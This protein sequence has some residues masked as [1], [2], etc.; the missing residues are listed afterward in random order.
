M[1]YSSFVV[2]SI[3]TRAKSTKNWLVYILHRLLLEIKFRL[4]AAKLDKNAASSQISAVILTVEPSHLFNLCLNSVQLQTLQ[5]KIIEIVRNISPVSHAAQEGLD[6]VQT[7]YYVHVDDDMVLAPSCFQRLYQTIST[8][9]NCAQVVMM[10]NDPIRGKINGIRMYR[11]AAVQSLGFHPLEE[12]GWDR[13]MRDKLVQVGWETVTLPIIV[14]HHHPVYLPNETFWKFRFFGEK[15][16]YYNT[17]LDEFN[18][19]FEQLTNYWKRTHDV[20]ALYGLAG[21]FEGLQSE[22]INQPLNYKDREQYLGFQKFQ[23]FIQKYSKS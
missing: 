10:L 8:N 19:Y 7:P 5:P 1:K 9:D 20:I 14:G 15:I 18:I 23:A 11:T 21:L 6:R 16:R 3:Y 22:E 2:S 12:K 17:G 4:R 13:R